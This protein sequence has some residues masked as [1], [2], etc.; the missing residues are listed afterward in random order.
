MPWLIQFP[1]WVVRAS[2]VILSWR[3]ADALPFAHAL[4]F[5][6][7]AQAQSLVPNPPAA[8]P[9]RPLRY[10]V[11]YAPGGTNDVVARILAPRLSEALGQP[12]II[13]NLLGALPH[14]RSGRLRALGHPAVENVFR[15]L[16]AEPLGLSGEAVREFIRDEMRFWKTLLTTRG[17][18]V[19]AG[20]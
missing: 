3:Y 12:V 4:L 14:V 16:G 1:A 13:E 15:N 19:E 20:Q 10:I 9:T 2:E 7:A 6:A 5:A 17:I 11:L 18:R 8:F